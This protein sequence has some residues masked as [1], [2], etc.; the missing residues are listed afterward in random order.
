VPQRS[1]PV[2]HLRTISSS[3]NIEASNNTFTGKEQCKH[4]SNGQPHCG[5]SYLQMSTCESDGGVTLLSFLFVLLLSPHGFL[6]HSSSSFFCRYGS[7]PT[8]IACLGRLSYVDLID[9]CSSSQGPFGTRFPLW[10]HSWLTFA[11]S[12]RCNGVS[13]VAPSTWCSTT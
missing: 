13:C 5:S 11:N 1:P 9:I 2:V 10:I 8:S 4:S 6:I 12:F 7:R 3:P